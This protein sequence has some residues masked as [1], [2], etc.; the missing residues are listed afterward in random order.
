MRWYR[1]FSPS[2]P[3]SLSPSPCAKSLQ[4]CP[5]LCNP[6]D[7]GPPGSSV[8]GILQARI[9]EWV[10][11]S[12]SRGSSWPKDQTHIYYISCI[13]RQVLYHYCHLESPSFSIHTHTHTHTHTLSLSLSLIHRSDLCICINHLQVYRS[14]LEGHTNY[15][16][17]WLPLASGANKVGV[18]VRDS[19]DNYFSCFL[20][21]SFFCHMHVLLKDTKVKRKSKINCRSLHQQGVG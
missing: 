10:A 7:C 18:G 12:S 6:M 14:L 5:T 13:G 20:L 8:H 1:M 4:S 21:L 9:L 16:S 3:P 15:W 17:L 2:L 11:I 19:Q